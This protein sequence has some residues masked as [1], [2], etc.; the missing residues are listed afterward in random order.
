MSTRALDAFQVKCCLDVIFSPDDFWV[1]IN[2]L[3]WNVKQGI[4]TFNLIWREL[5]LESN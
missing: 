3:N 5:D 1:N 2:F 4:L